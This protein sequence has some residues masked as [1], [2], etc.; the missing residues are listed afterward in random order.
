M[1]ITTDKRM[2]DIAKIAYYAQSFRPED[3][4]KKMLDYYQQELNEDIEEIEKSGAQAEEVGRY[5]EKFK[6]FVYGYFSKES[7]CM[8]AM[9]TGPSH[10]PVRSNEKK[11][12]SVENHIEIFNQWRLRAKRAIKRANAPEVTISGEL[13]KN[14]SKL[15]QLKKN[16]E[17]MKL[18]NSLM[19]KKVSVEVIAKECS[20]S[21][22]LVNKLLEPDFCGRKGFPQYQL[23]NNLATIKAT[24]ER[25]KVLERKNENQQSG[26]NQVFELSGVKIEINHAADRIQVFYDERPDAQTISDLK[27]RAF[28]WSP[29]NKCWQ[30]KI[31]ANAMSDTRQYFKINKH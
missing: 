14:L 27:R 20:L 31:T 17:C 26:E 2:Q 16:H 10:F 28:K 5:A 7:R 1:N 3:R 19:R 12:R 15:A 30:R 11:Q 13:E 18:F 25:I 23:T 4:G 29:S 9:I 6:Q 22:E 21:I 24:E 8:N